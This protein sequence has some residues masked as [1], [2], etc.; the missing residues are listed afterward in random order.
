MPRVKMTAT[1]EKESRMSVSLGDL[2]KLVVAKFK[3]W[4]S[5]RFFLV[6]VGK[7]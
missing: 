6:M 7:A 1:P 5:A 3:A 2:G 4:Q